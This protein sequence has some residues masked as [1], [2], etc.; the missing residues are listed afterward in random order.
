[1]GNVVPT[2][3]SSMLCKRTK[4]RGSFRVER[5]LTLK[6]HYHRGTRKGKQVGTSAYLHLSWCCFFPDF[7]TERD[8]S[9]LMLLSIHYWRFLKILGSIIIVA[10]A[11]ILSM[12]N[13]LFPF[14]RSWTSSMRNILFWIFG[15]L[16]ILILPCFRHTVKIINYDK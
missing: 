5:M 16:E 12:R 15:I 7:P 10:I 11:Y 14:L 2:S 1:M 3:R 13:N 9:R 8:T 6:G 4:P